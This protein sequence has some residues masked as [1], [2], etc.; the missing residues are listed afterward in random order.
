LSHAGRPAPARPPVVESDSI[1]SSWISTAIQP[2]LERSTDGR[3]LNVFP[4]TAYLK[5]QSGDVLALVS[6]EV[7]PGPLA[8]VLAVDRGFF[9][10]SLRPDE[11]VRFGDKE[12]RSGRLTI[13]LGGRPWPARP[14]WEAVRSPAVVKAGL[15][16]LRQAVSRFAPPGSLAALLNPTQAKETRFVDEIRRRSGPFLSALVRCARQPG[17]PADGA[18][19]HLES[20][21]A[22][23]AGLGAGFTP[24]GD[25]FLLGAIYSV[26][27]WAT[28]ASAGDLADVIAEAAAPRTTTV[29]G[30]YLRAGAAGAAGPG[31]HRLIAA[32]A[33][34]DQAAMSSSV[35]RL[36]RIG[37]TSGADA[38]T[39]YVLGLGVSLDGA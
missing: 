32:L 22:G 5:N 16:S 38:L 31:W 10:R 15:P 11:A 18:V 26:W 1:Q 27:A 9:E 23:L 25:D 21:A 7:G 29:S 30:A 20:T 35:S 28:E 19:T 24:A 13:R 33:A 2:A 8:V 39:G 36:C 3:V 12:I 34:G 6:S 37:H 4:S 14:S 17:P